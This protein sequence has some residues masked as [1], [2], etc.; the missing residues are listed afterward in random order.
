[1]LFHLFCMFYIYWRI[2]ARVRILLE[3]GPSGYPISED[4]RCP[5]NIGEFLF[6]S[7]TEGARRRAG[8][9]PPGAHTMPRRR[10]TPGRA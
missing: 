2:I 9:G 6:Y 1:M 10:P 3:K 5:E 7:K 4:Q 8:G